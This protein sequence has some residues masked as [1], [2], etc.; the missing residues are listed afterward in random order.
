MIKTDEGIYLLP[1][2]Y[3][4]HKEKVWILTLQ[5]YAFYPFGC[6]KN[7]IITEPCIKYV[8]QDS[9]HCR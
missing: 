5:F 1:E 9:F 3:T 7:K 6:F 2:L 4:V 8:R